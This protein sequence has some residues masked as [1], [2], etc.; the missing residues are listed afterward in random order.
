M[1]KVSVPHKVETKIATFEGDWTAE[2]IDAGLA[3]EPRIE[4]HVAWYEPTADGPQEVTDP[5]RIQELEDS[6]E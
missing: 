2:Q 4:S 6:I 5:V 1:D 3:G